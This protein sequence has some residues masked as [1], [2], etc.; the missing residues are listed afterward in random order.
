MQLYYN[1]TRY[2]GVAAPWHRNRA[3]PDA[4]LWLASNWGISG[5]RGTFSDKRPVKYAS[6]HIQTSAC[7]SPSFPPS[8]LPPSFPPPLRPAP[9][10]LLSFSLSWVLH[11][12]LALIAFRRSAISR[13]RKRPVD[14]PFTPT[15]DFKFYLAH[16]VRPSPSCYLS[17]IQLLSLNTKNRDFPARLFSIELHPG[18]RTIR[19]YELAPRGRVVSEN[20]VSE[21]RK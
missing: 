4:R 6:I 18:P 12:S 13:A 21:E 19:K 10:R 2:Y 11:E 15:G 20:G 1:Y 7:T 3:V 9:P 5:F 16:P 8:S 14:Q 17:C